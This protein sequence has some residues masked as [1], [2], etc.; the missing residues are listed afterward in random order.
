[1]INQTL[2]YWAPGPY[3]LIVIFAIFF[4]IFVIPAAVLI[5]LFVIYVIQ[6]NKERRRF[7][8]QVEKLTEEVSKLKQQRQ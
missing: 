8:T 5:I 3:E 2:A 7:R 6:N 4:I 1:M